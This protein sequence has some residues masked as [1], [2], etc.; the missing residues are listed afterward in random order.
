M[1]ND[2]VK[3]E[4]LRSQRWP[5]H[6][7]VSIN[8]FR[9]AGP[10]AGPWSVVQTFTVPVADMRR[11]LA[12]LVSEAPVAARVTALE[13]AARELCLVTTSDAWERL[14]VPAG[15]AF[16]A[17]IDAVNALAKP[18]SSAAATPVSRRPGEGLPWADFLHY[19]ARL[20]RAW[21]AEGGTAEQS[22]RRLSMDPGQVRLILAG[23][24][25]HD[26]PHECG[27]LHW[28]AAPPAEGKDGER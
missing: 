13:A 19:R 27:E 25:G 7:A 3:I 4:I 26:G 15:R 16:V 14:P 5:K 21:E 8:D 1:S 2:R 20:L 12:V 22:A 11:P 9:V 24:A 28:D 18:D 17:L 6:L 23:E 10:D